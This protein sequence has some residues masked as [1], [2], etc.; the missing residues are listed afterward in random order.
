MR[1]VKYL[2]IGGGLAAVRA[3]QQIRTLD[4]DGAVLAVSDEP[5]IPYDR[6]PLSKDYLAGEK[7]IEAIT[8]ESA[9][10]LRDAKIEF[11]LGHAVT[12]LDPA[13]KTATL[14]NGE[15]ISFAKALIATGGRPVHLDLPG[16][17]L[18]GIHY[19]RTAADADA[20]NA[21]AKPGKKAVIIGGGFIG[22][23]TAATL[24]KR[25]VEVTVIEALPRVWQ[26]FGSDV[27]SNFVTE[28]CKARGVKFL[29]STL[30]SEFRGEGRVS[31]VVTTEEDEIP[32]DLVCVGVGIRPNVELATAAGLEVDNGIVVDAQMRTSNPDIYAAG[33]VIN[34]F[35]PIFERRHRVEHWGHAEHSG[36]IAGRAMAGGTETYDLLSYVWSDI[37]D[38][39]F[40]FA[41]D[42]H[43][44]DNLLVRGDPAA[45]EFMILYMKAGRVTA[46]FSCNTPAREYSMIRRMIQ[47][48]KDMSARVGELTDTKVSLR[49]LV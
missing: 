25:G 32:C 14:A 7:S 37:F 18:P 6:P 24:R 17:D 34:Y 42:E 21:D 5:V 40:E 16:A 22:L 1:E 39:H 19:L 46:F 9:D 45:N 43:E 38:L 12:K 27:L 30:V 3:A 13:A 23:E 36:Q 28:Y 35:D 15:E 33:D 44:Y 48:K 4:A 31:A 8:L 26:R 20:I 49:T 29:F 41:G 2:L 47:R 10:K 11:A